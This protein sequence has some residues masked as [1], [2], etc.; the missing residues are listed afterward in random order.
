[1]AGLAIFGGIG[2]E[3]RLPIKGATKVAKLLGRPSSRVF[4]ICR[5]F[6]V[7]SFEGGQGGHT[8]GG[9]MAAPL[10]PTSTPGIYK[11]GTRYVFRF[12]DP[13]GKVRQ[14]S[15]R[16]IGEAKR[17]RAET[18]ADVIRGEYRAHSRVTLGDYARTWGNTYTGRT[19][20]GVRPET[21]ADYRRDLDLYVIPFFGARTLLASIEPRHVKDFARSLTD[22]GLTPN[23]VRVVVAP[24]R[25]LLATAVEGGLIRHNPGIGLRVA[26]V[27]R[28]RRPCR[29]T[30]WPR[31]SHRCPTCH[32]AAGALPCLNRPAH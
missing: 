32:Q 23:T 1:M 13:Q 9:V 2:P 21:L 17:L 12:R 31:S 14:R 26:N 24:L 30:N 25:A 22:R 6:A 29:R 4:M 7:I 28:H 11:R 5:R 8:K 10:V 18:G 16:T 3:N 27:A 15:A 19:G 20:R